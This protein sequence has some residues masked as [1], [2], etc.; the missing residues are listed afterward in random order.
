MGIVTQAFFEGALRERTF[1]EPEAPSLTAQPLPV[2]GASLN[3]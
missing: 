3:G 1:G 2:P